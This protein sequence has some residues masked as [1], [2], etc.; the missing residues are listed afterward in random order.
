[1]SNKPTKEKSRTSLAMKNATF[2]ML[3]SFL[4]IVV[5]FISRTVFIRLL[6]VTYLGVN[7]LLASILTVLSLADLGISTAINFS[8]YKPV[9]THDTERIKSILEVYKIAYRWIAGIILAGGLLILPFF[10]HIVKDPE[11][12]QYAEIRLFYM[13][14]L[15]NTVSSYFISYKYSIVNAEQKTYIQTNINT[16]TVLVTVTIQLLVLA[17]TRNYVLYLATA[18]V[19]GL[20]QIV[21]VNAFLNKRYP[22]FKD[23]NVTPLPVSERQIIKNN[24][25]ALFIN[26]I[27]EVAS[28]QIDNLLVSIYISISQV[29]II[30][31]Y[32]LIVNS[33]T[34]LVNSLFSSVISGFGNFAASES[35][36]KQLVIFDVY[37]F[38]GFWI[39]GV[40]SVCLLILINP[41]IYIWI[42][43]PMLLSQII[44]ILMLLDFYAKGHR[45]VVNN[46]K[47]AA[48]IF[49]EDKYLA[50]LR[51]AVNLGVSILLVRIYGL[52]GIFIGTVVSGMIPTLI[53]PWI[54]YSRAFGVGALVY[55]KK[56]LTYLFAVLASSTLSMLFSNHILVDVNLLNLILLG[57]FGFIITNVIF[58]VL[59]RNSREMKYVRDNLLARLIEFKKVRG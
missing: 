59:F 58:Y 42:G 55:Y 41:F 56:S 34:T 36:G 28:M 31:N 57:M 33:I 24:V 20:L 49:Q 54:L 21:V 16:I 10:E 53:R 25:T 26:K 1:M 29:G 5:S 8:L 2:S 22:V 3:G 13:F 11:P 15:F 39:Y 4:T 9:A 30:S 40:L 46:Y 23:R 47:I 19:I 51:G 27:G 35:K 48:G 50:L 12:I 44:V 6:G 38:V 43:E 18:S 7:G 37:R 17:L 32:V 45:L 52:V 14:F